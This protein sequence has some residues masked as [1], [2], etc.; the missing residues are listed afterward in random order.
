MLDLLLRVMRN[1]LFNYQRAFINSQRNAMPISKGSDY[2]VC[3]GGFFAIS[4]IP[5][6]NFRI[7]LPNRQSRYNVRNYWFQT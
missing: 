4:V 2:A 7:E 5:Q 6:S 1:S 3:E